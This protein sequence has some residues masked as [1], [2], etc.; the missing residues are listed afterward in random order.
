[1]PYLHMSQVVSVNVCVHV[2][3]RQRN[4][5]ISYPFS[6]REFRRVRAGVTNVVSLPPK[7]QNTWRV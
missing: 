3:A 5:E 1:M 4:I 7:T 6:A 2:H